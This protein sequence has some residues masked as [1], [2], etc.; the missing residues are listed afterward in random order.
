M[1]TFI[2]RPH[3]PEDARAYVRLAADA[4]SVARAGAR[5]TESESFVA[6][7]HSEANPAGRS[8]AGLAE[9]EGRVVGHVS[10]IP[11][12][13]RR[14]DGAAMTCWQL[15]LFAVAAELQRSGLGGKLLRF[16]IAEVARERP[17]ECAYGYPNP[18]S[19]GLLLH[20]GLKPALEVPAHVV[21]PR[22]RRGRLRDAGAS[23]ELAELD[24][25][26]AAAALER[27]RVEETAPGRFVRDA[28]FFRW[29]FLGPDADLRYR[30]LALERRG[31]GELVLL[32]LAEHAA[33]GTS[34]TVLV[35]GLPD[36]TEGRMGLALE[37]ARSATPRRPVYVTTNAR[38][39]GG[40][41]CVRVPRRFDPRPVLPFLLPGS[42]GFQP[43]LGGAT[44]LTGDWM[45]F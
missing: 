44:Y 17:G 2:S 9:L 25:A 40:P 6:H 31:S 14:R 20:W 10:G 13:F 24:A 21:L 39:R 29:R 22:L 15:G 18:R 45:S 7:I 27:V 30:F 26:G 4:F 12:R 8:M 32:A 3:L 38:W 1:T 34:F 41:A 23:W 11:F 35:D 16:L 42:E 5:P 33:L 19:V 36:L 28:A 37:A 43:E